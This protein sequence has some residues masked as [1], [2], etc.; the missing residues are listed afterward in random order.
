MTEMRWERTALLSE[1]QIALLRLA[2]THGTES[3]RI[4]SQSDYSPTTIDTYMSEI[5][6]TLGG[7]SRPEAVR[8]LDT[9]QTH[10]RDSRSRLRD[11]ARTARSP[12]E[13]EQAIDADVTESVDREAGGRPVLREERALFD[14]RAPSK[15]WWHP[16]QWGE[17]VAFTAREVLYG[18]LALAVIAIVAAFVLLASAQSLQ[19]TL[20]SLINGRN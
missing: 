1:Q 9:W 8:L 13:F 3:K 4:A 19:H 14:M 15:P 18:I 11:L 5:R 6:R 17:D 10:S 7:P 16:S 20:L 12:D 2:Q